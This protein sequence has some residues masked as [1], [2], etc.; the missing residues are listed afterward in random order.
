MQCG[1]RVVKEMECRTVKVAVVLLMQ[2]QALAKIGAKQARR[3]RF[4]VTAAAWDQSS[5]TG[6]DSIRVASLD[7]IAYW[8]WLLVM[9]WSQAFITTI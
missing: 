4:P 6:S 2:A 1:R 9:D 7:I 5:R 3:T 8:I